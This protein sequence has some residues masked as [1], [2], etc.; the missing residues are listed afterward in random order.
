MQLCVTALTTIGT[1][2][3]PFETNGSMSSTIDLTKY[4]VES[5][6]QHVKKLIYSFIVPKRCGTFPVPEKGLNTF[7]ISWYLNYPSP[8]EEENIVALGP[9]DHQGYRT[10]KTRKRLRPGEELVMDYS[11]SVPDA[12]NQ[13][14]YNST[15]VCRIC[16]EQLDCNAY[17][18]VEVNCNCTD[19]YFHE[20]CANKWFSTKASFSFSFRNNDVNNEFHPT[21]SVACEVCSGMFSITV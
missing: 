5:L 6:P 20:T 2:V 12:T 13:A 7:D 19:S 15:A 18:V 3:N 21:F 9:L 8:T 1:N 17:G 10:M 11:L 4:E 14:T 16:R